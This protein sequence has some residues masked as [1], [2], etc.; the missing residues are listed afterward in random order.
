MHQPPSL[1]LR[2]I[3]G[4]VRPAVLAGLGALAL[5]AMAGLIWKSG[6]G[7][8]TSGATSG[9]VT[10]ASSLTTAEMT[11]GKSIAKQPSDA[12]ATPPTPSFKHPDDDG[13]MRI[14]LADVE[15]GEPI[16]VGF[17]L[18]DVQVGEGGPTTGMLHLPSGERVDIELLI[19]PVSRQALVAVDQEGLVPGTYMIRIKTQQQSWNPNRRF[20]IEVV[21]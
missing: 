3:A 14:R 7:D 15:S 9:D 6:S 5:L 8:P 13:V 4:A 21:D 11:P 10:S 1:D 19:D 18:D 2:R 20:L 17:P 16:R 12:P